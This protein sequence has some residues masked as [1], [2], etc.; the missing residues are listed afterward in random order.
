MTT[1]GLIEAVLQAPPERQAAIIAAA[2]GTDRPRPGTAAEAAAILGCCKKSLL[3][4]ARMGLVN[5]I[6]I[7]QRKVKYDLN[8]VEVLA[9]RGAAAVREARP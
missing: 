3:R 7:T 4:Y 9:T 1:A 2:R 6:K 8:E 5:Q